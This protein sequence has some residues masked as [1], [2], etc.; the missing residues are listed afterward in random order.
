M[1]SAF[2]LKLLGF[3][4]FIKKEKARSDKNEEREREIERG[5]VRE[6]GKNSMN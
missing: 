1:R 2:S 3:P 4:L 5:K 6:G